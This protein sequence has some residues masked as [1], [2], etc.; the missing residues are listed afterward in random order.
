M[1]RFL[2]RTLTGRTVLVL[3]VGLS[4]SHLVSMSIYSSDRIDVL[5]QLGGQDTA[6]HLSNI[7]RMLDRTPA[8]QR[9]ALVD[10]VDRD[11][12][13]VS[14]SEESPLTHNLLPETS[15]KALR[16]EILTQLDTPQKALIHVRVQDPYAH[17]S[18][19]TFAHWLDHWV[20]GIV[21]H[22]EI[23]VSVRLGELDDPEQWV[24]FAVEV[25]QLNPMWS[26]KSVLSMLAMT[27][28]VLG[29]SFWVVHRLTVPLRNFAQAATRLGKDVGAPPLDET[30]PLEIREAAM[31]FN[32]MQERLKRLVA[33]RTEMLAAISHDLRTPITLLRLRSEL[34][35][36]EEERTKMQAT[37]DN[38]EKMI[39]S[40]MDFARQDAVTEERRKVDLTALVASICDDLSD[41]GRDV[42]FA[43]T[44]KYL[45]DC[46]PLAL[47]RAITN[48]IDNALKYGQRADVSMK[49]DDDAIT[50]TV[51][52]HG[53]GIP[54]D[55]LEEVFQPFYRCDA[56]RN[57]ETGGTG[58]GLSVV[59]S[60][61]H[62]HGGWVVLR[63]LVTGGLSA[64]LGLPR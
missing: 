22:R 11:G 8:D 26:A 20:Q 10:T 13:H 4:L 18:G 49:A 31:A 15:V 51:T 34:I 21:G 54:T 36:D 25:P 6:R 64:D 28:A 12:F 37:L 57:P 14:L 42:Q 58:L 7:T 23:Q 17:G 55:Q 29:M 50:I 16:N 63:N 2:P 35:E 53:P 48:L 46:R 33:N 44:D 47:Q 41:A 24:N 59:Q 9:L 61:A 19:E 45:Y 38:M 39:A 27:V 43:E 62:A 1:L 32:Q 60:V 40:T 52:D 56:S 5:T 3:L 30:G